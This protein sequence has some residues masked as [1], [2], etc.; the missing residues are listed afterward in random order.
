M[1]IIIMN[2]HH[3][4]FIIHNQENKFNIIKN[5]IMNNHLHN[6]FQI[7]HCILNHLIHKKIYHNHLVHMDVME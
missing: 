1:M 7:I 5:P 6:Y 4:K 3:N 2:N